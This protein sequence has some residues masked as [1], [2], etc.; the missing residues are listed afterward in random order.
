M[1]K[2]N[3]DLVATAGTAGAFLALGVPWPLWLAL[4]ALLTYQ[5]SNR[6]CAARG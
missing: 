5:V 3:Y 6:I 2:R 4:G 1:L